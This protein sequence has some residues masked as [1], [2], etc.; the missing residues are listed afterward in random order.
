MAVIEVR[1]YFITTTW[2]LITEFM[3][4]EDCCYWWVIK[5]FEDFKNY[6]FI[7]KEMLDNGDEKAWEE[8]ASGASYDDEIREEGYILHQS[9]T[10]TMDAAF[11]KKSYD[12]ELFV[13]LEKAYDRYLEFKAR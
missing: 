1:E 12:P 3:V 11:A 8:E 4:S 6:F 5:S 13:D 10:M 9:S 7:F 2:D